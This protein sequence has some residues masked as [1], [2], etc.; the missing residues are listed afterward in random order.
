M[1]IAEKCQNLRQLCLSKCS[2]LTDQTLLSLAH[3][4][5]YLNTLEIAGC[6]QFTDLGFQSLS[7]VGYQK[8][9]NLIWFLK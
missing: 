5:P 6:S 3:H 7:K 9:I 4:N 2:D 1:K 8:L